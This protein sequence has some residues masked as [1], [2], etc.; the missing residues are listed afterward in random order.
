MTLTHVAL[1]GQSAKIS[2]A[3]SYE[4]WRNQF[5][6]ERLHILYILGL[7]ANPVFIASDFLLYRQHLLSFL[8]IRAVLELGLIAGFILL[9]QQRVPVPP[10]LLLIFWIIFPNIWVTHMTM[11]LGGFTSGY[12]SGMNLVFLA[13]AVI[14][15]SSWRSHLVSQAV[16]LV[17]YYVA[18]FV[19]VGGP[20]AA[21]AAIENSF[22]LLW[23]CVALLFSVFLYERLQRAEFQARV[24]EQRARR[25]LEE[26]HT[27][28]LELDGLKSE[29]FAN[30]SHELRTP[31]TLIL[32]AYRSLLKLPAGSDGRDLIQAG[33]RNT[34]RLLYLIN[35]LLD[36]AKFEGG[37]AELKKQCIDFAALV[38]GVAANFESSERPR[39][40]CRG[41]NEPVALE[42]DPRQ[43]KKVPFNLLAKG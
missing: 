43:L 26:S 22:F 5:A 10:N 41:V 36:L 14:V 11:L 34:S 4:D 31:L 12:Y 20:A 25:E 3:A 28:L 38:R 37:R 8:G 39:V 2:D 9:R 19:L 33:L 15:P 1:A 16:T 21:S 27:K 17:Y 18:N 32:G 13:A 40:H 7:I 24:S 42:G 29:F 35:E 30:V 6:R 23:T